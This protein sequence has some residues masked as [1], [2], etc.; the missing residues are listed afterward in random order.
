MF[1]RVRGVFKRQFSKHSFPEKFKGKGPEEL[2]AFSKVGV[3][4][5]QS[6]G[7]Q[8]QIAY[9]YSSFL[10][11]AASTAP[12]SVHAP[13]SFPAG[14]CGLLRVGLEVCKSPADGRII[15]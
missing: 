1:S 10:K 4:S 8:T 2:R 13:V 6:G 14:G 11:N 15:H 12:L 5:P 9:P 3:A 7:D